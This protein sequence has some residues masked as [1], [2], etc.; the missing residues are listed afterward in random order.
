MLTHVTFDVRYKMKFETDSDA[1]NFNTVY[2]SKK[3]D[4]NKDNRK[5][6]FL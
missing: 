4:L 3:V 2:I 1:I 6:M 5:Y